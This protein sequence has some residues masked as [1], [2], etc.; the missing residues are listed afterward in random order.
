MRV[1]ADE[2]SDAA[3]ALASI[4][5]FDNALGSSYTPSQAQAQAQAQAQSGPSRLSPSLS[6]SSTSPTILPPLTAADRA[7][8]VAIFYNSGP[9]NGVLSGEY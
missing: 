7:K 2:D 9:E 4:D 6:S 8:F 5:G 1:W 3:G